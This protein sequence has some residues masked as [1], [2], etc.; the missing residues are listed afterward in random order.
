MI[1]VA[2]ATGMLGGMITQ[3]LLAQGKDVR[4]LVRHNSPSEAMAV[5]GMATSIQSL[6]DAGAQ[7]I[8]GDLKDQGSLD[9]AMAGVDT[10]VTTANSVLRNGEDNVETVD[11][12]GNRS[13]IEAAQAAAVEHFIFTSVLGA[14]SSSLIPLVRCK[15]E[16]EVALHESDM[17]YTILS[18][19]LL[20]EVWV[21]AVVGAPLQAG[22]PVTLVGEARRVHSFVSIADVAAFAVAA[23][24]NPAARNAR[25][26]IGGPEAVSWRDVVAMT[27]QVLGRELPVRFVQPGEP[28]PFLPEAVQQSIAIQDTYDSPVPMAETSAT[29]GVNLTPMETVLQHMF[30]EG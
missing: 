16:A 21:G 6:I 20:A 8:Y 13:L 19:N 24:E 15:A 30:G 26:V 7:P 25:V 1:L 10:V 3:Q 27:G 23:V 18:P 29:Y 4:I 11:C 22:Q 17:A 14:A 2:G 9:R 12:Q 28:V 5:Q